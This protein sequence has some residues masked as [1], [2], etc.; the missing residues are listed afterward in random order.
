MDEIF[1]INSSMLIQYVERQD[2]H[3][4]KGVFLS[5]I[6]LVTCLISSLAMHNFM[7]ITWLIGMQVRTII[8][9][10]VYRKVSAIL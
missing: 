1:K 4:W 5:I 10:V 7:H 3:S 2:P 9:A 6:L 8:N